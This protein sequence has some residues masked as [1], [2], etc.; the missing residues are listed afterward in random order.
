MEISRK[1]FDQGTLSGVSG[2][3][4]SHSYYNTTKWVQIL[5]EV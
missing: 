2:L 3:V 5:K 4:L 1:L